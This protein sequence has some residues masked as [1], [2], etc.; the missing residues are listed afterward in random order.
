MRDIISLTKAEQRG[1][2]AREDGGVG[3]GGGGIQEGS[4]RRFFEDLPGER[5]QKRTTPELNAPNLDIRTSV[6]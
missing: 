5:S 3:W 6:E 2:R 1:G 4:T